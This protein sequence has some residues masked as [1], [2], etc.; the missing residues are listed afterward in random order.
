MQ[1]KQLG[2]SELKVAE[3]CL[4]TM[5]YGQQNIIEDA[6]QQIYYAVY[7]GT[8]FIDIAEMYPVPTRAK[9]QGLTEAYVE[10]GSSIS[11]KID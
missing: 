9:T 10:N 7:C 2:E 4:D 3:I 5:T 1:Y 6:Y 11:N 8:N